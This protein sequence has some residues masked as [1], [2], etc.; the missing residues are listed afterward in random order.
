MSHVLAKLR[1]RQSLSTA[2]LAAGV[3]AADR[4]VE[5][6]NP[7]QRPFIL[8]A[9]P[10]LSLR[11][12]RRAGKSFA[13]TSKALYLAEKRP[14]IRVLIISLTLKS[15]KENYW[16][17][18]PGGLFAQQARYGLNLKFN[19]GDLTWVHPNGSRGRLAGAETRADIEYLRGAAA[20]ADIV[21]VDEAKS[22]SPGLLNELIRDVLEPG[23]M[24]RN[25]Q[26]CLGGTPGSIPLGAFYEATHPGARS[27][28]NTP[29]EAV[30]NIP[31]GAEGPLY[32][33]L[34]K[35]DLSELWE[36][37]SWDIK[38]NIAAPKQWERALRIKRKQGWEDSN[39]IWRREYLGEWVSN[40]MELVYQY[41]AE[42]LKST[43]RVS[44]NPLQT[45]ANP[46]GL[47]PEHGP[48]HL[49]LGLDLGY[50]DPTA[51]VLCAY[52]ETIQELRHI[53]DYKEEHLLLD[54]VDEEI[55]YITDRFGMPEVIVA[56][57]AGKQFLESLNQMKGHSIIA[58]EKRDKFDYVELLNNDFSGGRIKIIP[59]SPLEHE[60]CGLQ[61]DLSSNS[62][63]ILARTGKLREDPHCAN[64]SCDAL[65]YL[66]RFSYHYWAVSSLPKFEPGSDD[67]IRA[68]QNAEIRA[69]RALK[70]NSG[71]GNPDPFG[72]MADARRERD[73]RSYDN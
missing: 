59:N 21:F 24:T 7:T 44:W 55:Q 73:E 36:L 60:L 19:Y 12:P 52:S 31:Y 37:H 63:V 22:F 4:I 2:L 6:A 72:I 61:Y 40:V 56:D 29:D 39:P 48:W 66:W 8:S 11:C 46:T 70:S 16:S 25:G 28:P 42:K 51:L 13:V 18:A 71:R 30:V 41:A 68:A 67:A 5:G 62:K 47:P 32:D 58:A 27:N 20:E 64:H 3:E 9:A 50:E 69:R 33:N 38:D 45:P 10:Y 23:L 43:S 15:T 49:I 14:G 65:L 53:Y 54:G 1:N 26:L 17:A 35:D 34:S 57:G